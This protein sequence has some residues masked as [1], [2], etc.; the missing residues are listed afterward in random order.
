MSPAAE[1][2]GVHHGPLGGRLGKSEI[3][4]GRDLAG[5]GGYPRWR[6]APSASRTAGQRL[7]P[8]TVR[9]KKQVAHRTAEQIGDPPLRQVMR[10]IVAQ[11]TALTEAA[12]VAQ[13]VVGRIVIEVRGGEDDARR[14]QPYDRIVYPFLFPPSKCEKLPSFVGIGIKVAAI[15]PGESG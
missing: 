2:D 15:Q 9:P 7:A 12:Q 11:V 13:A 5:L 4:R 1:G 8:T 3:P 14:P 10:A 6:T